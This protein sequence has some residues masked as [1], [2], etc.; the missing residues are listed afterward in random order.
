GTYCFQH[1]LSCATCHPNDARVDALNWDLL[2]DGLG[3][4]KNNRSLLLSHQ[5]PP[6]MSR[7]VRATM[8]VATEAGFVHIL[9]RQPEGDTVEAT[10]EYLRSLK[11]LP[12]PYLPPGGELSPAAQRG[13]DIFHSEETACAVCHPPPLYTDLKLHDVGTRGPLDRH[14]EFDT[15]TLIELYRTAPYSHDGSA[16]DLRELLVDR[17][18]KD[19][20]GKTTHLT[21]QQVDDLIEFLLSL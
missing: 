5:T 20:H 10:S 15:P 12:S 8:E 9:F 6:T 14:S 11:P 3:N 16:V 17:N 7:G 19:R 4:P 1:W 2:N 13:K 18:R 21:P